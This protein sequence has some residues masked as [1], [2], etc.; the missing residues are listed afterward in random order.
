MTHNTKKFNLERLNQLIDRKSDTYS[1]F[2]E[3]IDINIQKEFYELMNKISNKELCEENTSIFDID[4]LYDNETEKHR[5]KEILVLLANLNKV[6]A[7]REIE[8]FKKQANKE[9]EKWSHI[10]LQQSRI[11]LESS[12]LKEKS[13]FIST[14][15]GGKE[16]KL[17]YFCVLFTKEMNELSN[18]EKTILKKEINFAF[19]K[20]NVDLET[21]EFTKGITTFKALIPVKANIKKLFD[22]IIAETNNYGN[23]LKENMI[24][25]NVKSLSIEEIDNLLKT[26]SE[27]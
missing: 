10:A 7:Y 17:R 11:M 25:T 26:K 16:N 18:K 4:E 5:K 15:L 22:D 14:G 24:I 27:E 12:L 6:E 23:I 21:L 9:M 1:I 19:N 20:V 3:E 8:K 2:E 13:V